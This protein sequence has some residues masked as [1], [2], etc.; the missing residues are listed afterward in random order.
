MTRCVDCDEFMYCKKCVVKCP[1]GNGDTHYIC[2][3][4]HTCNESG[5]TTRV[6]KQFCGF[7]DL[8]DNDFVLYC[9]LHHPKI[10]KRLRDEVIG[11][12]L[13]NEDKRFK[14]ELIEKLKET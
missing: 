8:A 6:C 3:N 13:K 4:R 9:P 12:I 11:Q 1:C 7:R 5:C 14:E 10:C 2:K